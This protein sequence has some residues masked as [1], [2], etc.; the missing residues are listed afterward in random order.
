MYLVGF[1]GLLIGQRLSEV[2]ETLLKVT[3][4]AVFVLG[5]AR[6]LEKML[7]VH[8]GSCGKS[9]KYDVDSSLVIKDRYPG[10]S[11]ELRRALSDWEP[12]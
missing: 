4:V 12:G 7:V 10:D 5:I 1:L 2:H 9:R 6:T 11:L 3:G 8:G